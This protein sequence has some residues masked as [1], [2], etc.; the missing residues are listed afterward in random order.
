VEEDEDIEISKALDQMN[1]KEK[2]EL[3]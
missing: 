3:N 1:D 2:E